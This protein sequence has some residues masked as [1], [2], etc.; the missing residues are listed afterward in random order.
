MVK[1][2]NQNSARRVV[3]LYDFPTL[4]AQS[5]TELQQTFKRTGLKKNFYKS[6]RSIIKQNRKYEFK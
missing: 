1:N 3:F 6:I 5:F 4:R 2:G